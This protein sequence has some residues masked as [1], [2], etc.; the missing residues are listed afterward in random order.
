MAYNFEKIETKQ[1]IDIFH[2]LPFRIYKNYKPWTPPFRFEVENIFDPME[3]EFFQKGECERFLVFNGDRPAA[4]FAVMNTP[5]RDKV[6]DPPMAGIGFIEMENDQELAD[7]MIEFAQNWHKKR[8]YSA[9]RGPVNFGENTI[10]WGLLVKNYREPPVYGMFYH[11]PYYKELLERTG[12]EKWDDHYSFKR[13]FYDP[14]PERMVR[15]TERLEER[16]DVELRPIDMNNIY[17]DA[18]Y[19]RE[20]YNEAWSDQDIGEREQEFTP[21]TRET[22]RNMVE[23]MK[24][25][26]LK[27]GVLLTFVKGDPASFLVSIPDLNEVSARTGGNLRW[28]HYPRLLLL[29]KRSRRLRTLVF[30]TKPEYRK[31]GLEAMSFVR[32][33]EWTRQA[34]K[35]LQQLEGGWVSEQ[36]WLMRRGLESLG[37]HHHKTHRTYR[38]T[39]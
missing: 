17:R 5:E 27:E 13:R 21:L 29:K 33:I 36:N 7:A 37:C 6:F 22:V 30:G 10:F 18:E 24:P 23:E 15:V 25:V 32:G 1:Q 26:V 11:P 3:N 31:M 8:G 16:G 28:W 9:M 20:I 19:I 35:R 39:F 2:S 14:L 4:R 38:W 34:N 12:A